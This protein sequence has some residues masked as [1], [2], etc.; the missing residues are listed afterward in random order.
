MFVFLGSMNL[1]ECPM[2]YLIPVW[3]VVGGSGG[4]VAEIFIAGLVIY[5]FFRAFHHR[6][7]TEKLLQ[8]FLFIIPFIL[9]LVFNLAWFFTGKIFEHF[10]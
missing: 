6:T 10:F 3:L 5:T 7:L 4:I 9:V 8:I 2:N 1:S